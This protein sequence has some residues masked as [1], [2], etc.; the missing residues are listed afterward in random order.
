[1]QPISKDLLKYLANNLL[2]DMKEEQYDV[3][4]DELNIMLNQLKL[5]DN[6]LSKEELQPMDFP[7]IEETYFLREDVPQKTISKIEALRNSSHVEA[8]QIKLPKVVD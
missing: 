3:L 5:M 4:V 6:S 8:G 7:F 1:M 2:L